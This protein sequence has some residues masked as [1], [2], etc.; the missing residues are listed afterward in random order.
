M[1][2][3]LLVKR[4]NRKKSNDNGKQKEE[5]RVGRYKFIYD[6]FKIKI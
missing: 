1:K 4:K 3:L 2:V 6:I 5:N